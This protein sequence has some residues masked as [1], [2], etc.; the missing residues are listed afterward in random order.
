MNALIFD[1]PLKLIGIV[2]HFQFV[3]SQDSSLEFNEP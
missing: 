2:L 1:S 3:E